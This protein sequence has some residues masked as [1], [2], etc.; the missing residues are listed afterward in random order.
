MN[1]VPG[2]GV[3]V[4]FRFLRHI[5]PAGLCDQK[6]QSSRTASKYSFV[7]Y[8]SFTHDR[9]VHPCHFQGVQSLSSPYPTRERDSGGRNE[10]QFVSIRFCNLSDDRVLN[11]YKREKEETGRTVPGEDLAKQKQGYEGQH[12]NCSSNHHKC[13]KNGWN[14]GFVSAFGLCFVG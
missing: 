12:P 7:T 8:S 14:T 5:C 6:Q 13:R 2:N 1:E 3:F 11:V 4:L 9:L 10:T